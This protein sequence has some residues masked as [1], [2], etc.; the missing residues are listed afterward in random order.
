MSSKQSIPA[1][2]K[3]I[4]PAAEH[5]KDA[6]SSGRASGIMP[7]SLQMSADPPENNNTPL[8]NSGNSRPPL[9]F[10]YPASGFPT[11]A[12]QLKQSDHSGETIQRHPGGHEEPAPAPAPPVNAPQGT[13]A[14]NASYELSEE[15]QEEKAAFLSVNAYGPQGVVPPI[16]AG[17]QGYGGFDATY[18][19]A[20][21]TLFIEIRGKVRFR[22]SL[23]MSDQVVTPT[24]PNF[25]GLATI[26]SSMNNAAARAEVVQ[27]YTWDDELKTRM[28]GEYHQSVASAANIWNGT[29]MFFQVN[30]PGWNDVRAHPTINIDITEEGDATSGVEGGDHIQV[31]VYRSPL[32]EDSARINQL[33]DDNQNISVAEDNRNLRAHVDGNPGSATSYADADPYTGAMNLD[34]NNLF[35]RPENDA[36]GQDNLLRRNVFFENNS[37]SLT[38][39]QVNEIRHFVRRFNVRGDANPTNNAVNLVGFASAPGSAEH[40]Q[41]LVNQRLAA[42]TEVLRGINITDVNA[43]VSYDATTDSSQQNRGHAEALELDRSEDV[44]RLERRVEIRIGSGDRQNTIAHELGHNFGLADEYSGRNRPVGSESSHHNLAQS[45]GVAEGARVENNDGIISMGNTIRE[46]HFSVFANALDQITGKSWH[47]KS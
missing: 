28:L 35:A 21:G 1:K 22:D 31:N 46:Q 32:P 20:S 18:Y 47:V 11:P 38:A 23:T 9:Q 10:S 7:P 5:E 41:R 42:V 37:A 24:H 16:F 43:S 4:A 33:I 14:D 45:A 40:N 29:N 36:R 2:A 26:L 44:Q 19:P 27:H 34:M 12:I 8:M 25:A 17:G 3:T 30:Q 6:Q 15:E 13:D 39:N